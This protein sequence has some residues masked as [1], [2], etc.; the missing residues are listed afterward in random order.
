M[1][2]VLAI[3]TD[4]RDDCLG[5]TIA[6]IGA[7][8]DQALITERVLYDDTGDA[9]HTTKLASWYPH[10]DV[11]SAGRRLGFAG[12]IDFVWR[13]LAGRSEARWVLA[14]EDDFTAT[15]PV[16]VADM[17]ALSVAQP[18]LTQVALRRQAWGAEVEYGG[19][20]EQAPSWYEER[21]VGPHTWV[22]T[23]RNY[24][25]NPSLFRRQL[26][27]VGWPTDGP[28]SEGR[29]GFYLRDHGLPWGVP[30]PEVRFGFLGSMESGREWVHHIGVDRVGTGY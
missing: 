23:T 13:R 10:F 5:Q 30:G 12:A 1:S 21:T 17:I 2:V 26:C 9:A 14:W 7:Q 25:T 20:I 11:L 4:G 15:R 24:T 27:A 28:H 18:H 8:V 22:E 6:S 29:F 19:F 16:P 3:T